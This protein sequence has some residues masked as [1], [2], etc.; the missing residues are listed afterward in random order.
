MYYVPVRITGIIDNFKVEFHI[1][2]FNDDSLQGG[3]GVTNNGTGFTYFEAKCITEMQV[4][5]GK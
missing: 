3:W 4:V 1:L 2:V 5:K